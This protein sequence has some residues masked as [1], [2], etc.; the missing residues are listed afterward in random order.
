MTCFWRVTYTLGGNSLAVAWF[1]DVDSEWDCLIVNQHC[2][3]PGLWGV[4]LVI[5]ELRLWPSFILNN[6]RIHDC[7]PAWR[8]GH[9]IWR[10]EVTSQVVLVM[11]ESG[12]LHTNV[13]EPVL[14]WHVFYTQGCWGIGLVILQLGLRTKFVSMMPLDKLLWS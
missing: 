6:T 8:P 10:L 12:V 7:F 2:S 1:L 13:E 4:G 9:D 14:Q 11:N 3:W 5:L